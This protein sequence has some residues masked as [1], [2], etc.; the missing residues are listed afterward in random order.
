LPSDATKLAEAEPGAQIIAIGRD[1]AAFLEGRGLGR[2]VTSIMH[3]SAQ[4]AAHRNAAAMERQA[5]FSAFSETLSMR[6]LVDVAVEI[7]RE[8]TVP[9]AMAAET[10]ARLRKKQDAEVVEMP[11]Q[12]T[13]SR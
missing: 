13:A 12:E 6:D 4:A 11:G 5:E 2:D 10:V 9:V 7:M 3:Y 1:A 8:N